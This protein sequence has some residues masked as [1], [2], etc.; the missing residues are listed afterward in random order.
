MCIGCCV[1]GS[2]ALGKYPWTV[3]GCLLALGPCFWGFVASPRG[4][5]VGS[6]LGVGREQH[7]CRQL[8]VAAFGVTDSLVAA[9]PAHIP[10][11]LVGV[12]SPSCPA[13]S[14]SRTSDPGQSPLPSSPALG[15][16]WL[17][18]GRGG[19]GA[20]MCGGVKREGDPERGRKLGRDAGRRR[21]DENRGGWRRRQK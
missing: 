5:S 11:G 1:S 15:R 20:G 10:E 19:G 8:S 16:S 14:C 6:I 18:G 17:G 7:S 4:L 12:P 13:C 3:E 2:L 21:R 9:G